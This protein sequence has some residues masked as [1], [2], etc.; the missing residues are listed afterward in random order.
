MHKS[1]KKIPKRVVSKYLYF[2]EDE[3]PKIIAEN[4]HLSIRECTCILGRRWRE[5]RDN[6]DPERS[7]KYAD[8]FEADKKRYEDEKRECEVPRPLVP[9]K[10]RKR[11]QSAY[12][13]YC[14][15]RRKLKPKI[16]MKEL[17]V[18]WAAVKLDQEALSLYTPVKPDQEVV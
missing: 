7:A 14:A 1:A 12:L 13:N 15:D 18:G 10:E 11:N 5:F 6:P 9:E 4:P 8:K 17:S 16:S 2:C 3:R